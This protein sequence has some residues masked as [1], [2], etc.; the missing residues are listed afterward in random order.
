[1]AKDLTDVRI[2]FLHIGTVTFAVLLLFQLFNKAVVAHPEATKQ[3][4]GQYFANKEL[5]PRRGSIYIKSTA[6]GKELYPLATTQELFQIQV[7]PKNIK[8]HRKVAD[9][10]AANLNLDKDQLFSQINNQKLYLPPLAR[11]QQ[12]E[13]AQKIIDASL[14][15]V[16]VVPEEVRFYPE[17]PLAAHILGFVNF[18]NKGNYGLEQFYDET[19][20]GY[21]G[22]VVAQRDSL[23]RF[24]NVEDAHPARDGDDLVLTIDQ[25]VQFKAQELAEQGIEKYGADNGLVM[26]MDAKTGGIVAIGAT[27]SY[28]P[29][30]FNEIKQ[31]EQNKF[32]NPATSL[33]WEPGSVLKPLVIAAGLDAE[34]IK[35]ED[36][37]NFG[38]FTVVQGYEI[39]TAQDKAFGK[40]NITQCLE[41]SDN[42]CLV[43]I[44][45]KIGSDTLHKYFTD[46]GFGVKTGVDMAGETTGSFLPLKNWRDIH[47]ATMSF[48][49]GISLT[50][51]QLMAGYTT[52]ANDGKL[53][54]PHLVEKIVRK[55]DNSVVEIKPKEIRQVLKPETAATVRQMLI[56]VVEHGHGKRAAVKGYK[57]GG[58][59]GTAQVAKPDGSGYEENAH[60]GGFIGIVPADTPRFVV[61][62][63]FDRP[64][65]VEFAES[66]AAPTVGEMAK[67]LL[68]YY[69]IPPTEPV[70]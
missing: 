31:E 15:G 6:D 19:L 11:R 16:I 61:F 35:P 27:G 59:T 39:H 53:V 26:V 50:P 25:N 40:E 44:G 67:F 9:T 45:D 55:P 63:K 21:G 66:S 56:S 69:Q 28:D 14:D 64:K 32:L 1:M 8:D 52:V 7:V 57:I 46:F 37:G 41:N 49:Q 38:N 70:Q 20:R 18:E 51:L 17:G 36:E 60:I 4:Q 12:K 29:N 10:L 42:V 13:I 5:P 2:R 3:A 58:K 23:G 24:I 22:K 65:N 30:K 47:R 68:N 43:W 33:T 62:S 48:G 34:K 54:T